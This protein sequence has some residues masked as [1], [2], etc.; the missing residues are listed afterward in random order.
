M[1]AL[2]FLPFVIV[3]ALAGCGEKAAPP[4]AAPAE[5]AAPASASVPAP[6]PTPA[7]AAAEAPAA[8]PAAAATPAASAGDLAKG[9]QVYTANCV[10]CHGGGVMGAPKFADKAAW[11][12]RVAK[13]K[14][15]L[16]N[17]ALNGFK[18][19]PPRGGNASLKD[20]EMKAAVDYMISKAS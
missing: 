18:L 19:M 4:A 13:G 1:K 14:D 2:Q 16:Y 17:S 10:S 8:A 9:E 6:A 3:A 7:P 20:E 15:A 5:Q 11:A 12:P